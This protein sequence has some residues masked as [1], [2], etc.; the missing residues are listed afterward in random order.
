MKTGIIKNGFLTLAAMLMLWT[1]VSCNND[2]EKMTDGNATIQFKLTDAPA[3]N[4]DEVNIDIVGVLVGVADDH[5]D[6]DDD[7][8]E[9]DSS[10]V[11][12]VELDVPNPG[13][14]NLLDFRNGE[15]VLLANGHIPA[16]KISQ[17]RLIL[18][19]ES[20][21]V[22]EGVS[23]DLATP[24]AQTSG[25]KFNLHETL[26]PDLA[27]SF[28]IDFDASRSVVKRGDDSYLL[29]PVIRTYADTY[30]GSI[31]GIA[32]P[33]DTVGVGYVQIINGED[34]LIAI[35]EDDGLFLFA[36]LEPA[37]WDLTIF[38]DTTTTFQDTVINDIE[39]KAGEVYNLESITLQH[40]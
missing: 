20:N 8:N 14:Y 28:V 38:A 39:V 36:G 12:W 33:A 6:L 22:V 4:Y 31:K 35:P 2:N 27:Y 15:T 7:D 23:H 34:T 19:D 21:V 25:L 17:V 24:S 5:D 18:G 30:G 13:L 37:L 9:I 1:M 29:K 3:L 32:L 11:E 26:L 40:D 16:G 10:E